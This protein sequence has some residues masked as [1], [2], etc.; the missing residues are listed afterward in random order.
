MLSCKISSLSHNRMFCSL[1]TGPNDEE[2]SAAE[3]E[4]Q[5]E[6]EEE[7]GKKSG[8]GMYCI[9]ISAPFFFYNCFE[10]FLMDYTI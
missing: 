2:D 3:S 5:E 9:L 6:S 7:G 8:K 1:N 4:E 10:K